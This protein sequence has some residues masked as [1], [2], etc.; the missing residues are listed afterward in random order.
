MRNP[1]APAMRAPEPL[2]PATSE[3][4]KMADDQ[5][6]GGARVRKEQ[7][8]ATETLK[9][10]TGGVGAKRTSCGNETTGGAP[11]SALPSKP[12]VMQMAQSLCGPPA[13]E[14]GRFVDCAGDVAPEN[15]I[16]KGRRPP[17]GCTCAKERQQREDPCK[18]LVASVPPHP[19]CLPSR[20]VDVLHT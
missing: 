1:Q 19:D 8:R 15:E 2:S 20:L 11:L 4:A 18:A 12:T 10:P 7:K 13:G 16:S 17:R 6:S 9:S 5:A 3:T 14:F